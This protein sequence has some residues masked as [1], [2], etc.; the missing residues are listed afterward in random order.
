VNIVQEVVYTIRDII[1][2]AEWR[3]VEIH[4][5]KLYREVEMTELTAVLL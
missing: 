1:V 2:V 5:L 4:P 3:I